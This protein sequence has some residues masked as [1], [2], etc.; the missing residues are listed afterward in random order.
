MMS[1]KVS[2]TEERTKIDKDLLRKPVLK[3]LF[4]R[5]RSELYGNIEMDFREI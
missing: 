1:E 4:V 3:R 5:L 2:S